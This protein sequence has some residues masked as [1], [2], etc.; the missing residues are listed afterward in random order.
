MK[1]PISTPRND[2]GSV[3]STHLSAQNSLFL[4]PKLRH[5]AKKSVTLSKKHYFGK[6][7]HFPRSVTLPK[8]PHFAKKHSF[9][10][11]KRQFA[12]KATLVI[13]EFNHLCWRS[14]ALFCRSDVFTKSRVAVT[15]GWRSE[16]LDPKSHLETTSA[17]YYQ[18]LSFKI[19]YR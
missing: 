1:A 9:R 12:K 11:K 10:Q 15:L 3:T 6:K 18:T 13:S 4:G 17:I 5:F 19:F 14:E 8:K 16:L 2:K 7:H